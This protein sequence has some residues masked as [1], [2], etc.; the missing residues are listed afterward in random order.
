MLSLNYQNQTRTFQRGSRWSG[1]A[2]VR[3]L[4]SP[5]ACKEK[6]RWRLG[7]GFD[8]GDFGSE[9][10]V[11]L[12]WETTTTCHRHAGPTRQREGE[13]G[14]R[15]K[16][17]EGGGRSVVWASASAGLRY[18]LGLQRWSRPARGEEGSRGLPD[19]WAKSR[20]ERGNPFCFI[21]LIFQNHFQMSFE[22]FF[23]I[24]KQTT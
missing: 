14:P 19:G 24:L 22:F 13:R 17:T 18:Y 16:E 21:F 10:L 5:K 23:W 8:V 1:G 9:D 20:E 12:R 6:G 15:N 2:R 11:G 7:G 3:A 4:N